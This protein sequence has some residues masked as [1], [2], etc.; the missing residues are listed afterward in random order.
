MSDNY[1]IE[2]RNLCKNFGSKQILKN[3]SLHIQK[4]CIYAL[5]GPNGAG[6]TTTIR[7]LTGILKPTSGEVFV[8]GIDVVKN[9]ELVRSEIG[10]LSQLSAGY[11]DFKTRDNIL[12]FTSIVG[13]DKHEASIK[14]NELLRLLEME[15]KLDLNFG[16][17]SG[18]EKRVV[19]LVRTIISSGDLIILDE[20]T[21][22]LDIARAKLVRDIIHDL[23]EKEGRT[24]VMS[25]H[26][27]SD[28]EDLATHTGILKDGELVFEGTK[29]EV[30]QTYA[31]G[32]TFEDAIITSFKI[33]NNHTDS[34]P[35][36]ELKMEEGK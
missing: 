11:K 5:L 17:L 31:P 26:I 1:I 8:Q 29:E 4:G 28:L 25:S 27:T 22:G 19:S 24:V 9:P 6:K 33:G 20:P 3:V 36:E 7:I 10:I 13:V 14:M 18:G 32:S 12:L 16:K 15:D 2:T 30:I 21:T 35:K 23:V 34:T